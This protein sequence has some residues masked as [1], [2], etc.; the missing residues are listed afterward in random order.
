MEFLDS[1]ILAYA[2]YDNEYTEECQEAIK[3]GGITN[4]FNLIEAFFIIEKETTR[5]RAQKC[6]KGL[7][8]SNI[9]IV[10]IDMNL[11]FEALKKI[12]QYKLSI[13]DMIH[14]ACAISNNCSSI[15]SYDADFDNL[16]IPR[17]EP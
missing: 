17:K 3:E 15:K 6:I 1:N 11:L 2:F 10:A 7:L 5:E 14:Y 4:T 12:N 8:K 13:F 16:E 9:Q